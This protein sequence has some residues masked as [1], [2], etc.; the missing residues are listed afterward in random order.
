VRILV[1]GA[2]GQ[3]GMT[4]QSLASEHPEHEFFFYTSKELDITDP[5]SIEAKFHE[6]KPEVAINCAAYTAV[7]QAE[8]EPE[9]AFAVNSDGV[10]N[11]V[12][13]CRNF[14]SAL[15]H[16]ST[17][18]VFDG[19]NHRPYAETDPVK[20]IGVYG[21]SKRAGEE[22]ILDSSISALIIRT[23]WVYSEFGNNFVKTMLRLGKERDEL[24]VIFDQIGTPSNTYDL[25]H[26]IMV[27]I[28]QKSKWVGNQEIFHFSNEGVCSWYDF[29][30]T[31]FEI[32]GIDCKVN[33]ILSKD[34]PT[35]AER[36][37][38]SVLDKTAFKNS[39]NIQ[40][41]NWRSSLGS[42][43]ILSND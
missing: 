30:L 38:Y 2:N 1:T 27:A 39:F 6:S 15:I 28:E 33:P 5:D 35:K 22:A 11:L 34:Y 9:K 23:S 7:D 12:E 8:N 43:V 25:A 26:A 42:S 41:P 36:P 40:I 4:F 20:P 19:T 21:Q 17:D 16:I 24:N 10:K 14:N 18:Y 32:A 29:A 37:H 31:I 3:L 13:A